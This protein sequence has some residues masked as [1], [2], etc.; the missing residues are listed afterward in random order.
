MAT[1]NP[2]PIQVQQSSSSTT[3]IDNSLSIYSPLLISMV[4]I[5]GTCIAIIA[6]HL[7]LVQYCISTRRRSTAAAEDH[8]DPP[9]GVDV[10]LLQ[11]IPILT[12]AAVKGGAGG[13]D[14]DECV[15]CLGELMD[16]EKVRLLPNCRHAFH[17]P[18]IDLWFAAHAS[19][20][21]CRSPIAEAVI[22]ESPILDP[23]A[24]ADDYPESGESS[25]STAASGSSET[26]P[27]AQQSHIGLLRHCAS[28]VLPIPA[29]RRA[30][31]QL[32]RSV[33]TGQTTSFVVIDLE[34]VNNSETNASSLSPSFSGGMLTWS[35]AGSLSSRSVS[36]FDRVSVKWLRSFSLMRLG[37]PSNRRILPY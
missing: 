21:M 24:A 36:H 27:G 4:G 28:V 12:Y 14:Q 15:V 17:V 26:S 8:A 37:K 23:P 20:P 19:C 11:T 5:I 7:F 29:E 2:P 13:A 10:K 30:P 35:T 16:E 22:A 31:P 25:Y 1:M 6:Y 34:G 9:A 18:C 3:T 32:K 33:S